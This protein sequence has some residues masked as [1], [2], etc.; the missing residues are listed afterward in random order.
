MSAAARQQ[1]Q[2]RP[3]QAAR[4]AQPR[5][6]ALAQIHIAK[7]QLGLDDDAYRA[8]LWGVARVRSSKDLDHAG[9]TAVLE[10]LKK[11]G[12][13][14]APPKTPTPGRPHNMAVPDREALLAKIEAHVLESERGW[15]YVDG[16]ARQMFGLDKVAFCRPH[17]L[18]KI[19]AA[20]EIDR[21]RHPGRPNE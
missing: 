13:K 7:K 14:S 9:R 21:R 20:L 19:V 16:I 8:M 2:R 12:F 5:S 15:A 18:H 10:H 3:R 6:S 11:C 4:P 17:Q 1:G